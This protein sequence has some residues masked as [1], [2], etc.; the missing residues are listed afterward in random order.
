M[1]QGAITRLTRGRRIFFSS[2]CPVTLPWM[3]ERMRNYFIATLFLHFP[4]NEPIVFETRRKCAW[5]NGWSC[6]LFC[7]TQTSPRQCACVGL[8]ACG[9]HLSDSGRI[10]FFIIS[11]FFH[12]DKAQN[13]KYLYYSTN[14]NL[15]SC[16]NIKPQHQQLL[17]SFLLLSAKKANEGGWKKGHYG[18]TENAPFSGFILKPAQQPVWDTCIHY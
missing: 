7:L 15:W 2:V 16:K 3:P 1:L 4:L 12:R 6:F 11:R 5:A 10:F 17:F 14:Y 13:K 18:D 9:L 8:N